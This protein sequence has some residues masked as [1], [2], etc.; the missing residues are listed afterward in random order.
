M[1]KKFTMLLA[2]LF[3]TVGTA[4]AQTAEIAA[5]TNVIC[6]ENQYAMKSGNGYWMTSFTSPTNTKPGRFAFFAVNGK[7]DTYQIYSVDR[8]KWVSYQKI[9]V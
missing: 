7:E 3:L 1:R 5:S 9:M 4:W 8:K 2:S 6:P